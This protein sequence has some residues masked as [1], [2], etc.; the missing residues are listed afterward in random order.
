MSRSNGWWLVLPACIIVG[1][2]MLLPTLYTAVLSFFRYSPGGVGTNEWIGL[3]N[4]SRLFSD[5]MFWTT[6]GNTVLFTVVTVYIELTIGLGLALLLNRRFQGRGLIRLAIL[7]PWALP[8]ALTAL[9][10]RWLYNTDFGIINAFLLQVG[11]INQPINWLG[12][13][14]IAMIAMMSVAIWKTSSFMALILLAG[15]QSIPGEIY[16]AAKIDGAASWG[17]LRYITLPLLLPTLLVS[18]ILRS[19]DAFRTFELPLNLTGG[20][21]VNSTEVISTYAYQ[22]L[23]QYVDFGY[24]STLIMSQFLILLALQLVYVRFYLGVSRE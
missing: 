8:T 11:L 20:G 1:G 7:F 4:Y 14:P 16:E 17:A 9:M 18:V 2:A 23:F 6:L 15:L 22:R 19:M 5:S 24:G 21:P 12:T 13:V 3:A 10:W